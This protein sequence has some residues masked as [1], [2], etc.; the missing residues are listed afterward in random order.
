MKSLTI[1]DEYSGEENDGMSPSKPSPQ[2]S[3]NPAKKEAARVWKPE[4]LEDTRR[5]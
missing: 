2:R 4:G 5:T 1:F 3:G